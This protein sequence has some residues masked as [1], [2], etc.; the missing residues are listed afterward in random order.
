MPR[1][2]TDATGST[3]VPIDRLEV[4]AYTV[5]TDAPES[6]GKLEWDSTT[7]V[8]VTAGAGGATGLG[9][10]YQ[11]A[12]AAH[13]IDDLLAP[14]LVGRDALRV[15][16]RW[17]EMVRAVRN[18][19]FPGIAAYAI[20]AVDLALW[21][22]KTRLLDLSLV[23]LLDAV[24][25]AV[26][27]Y[28]SG[29]FTSYPVERLI[30]QLAGW[31]AEGFPAVKMKVGRHPG[32]DAARVAAV[33]RAVGDGV[34][35]FVDANGAFQRQAALRQGALF[36]EHRVSWFEEPVSSDDV[37]GLRLLRDRLPAGMEVAAGEYGCHLGE[38][39]RLL[40]AGAVDCL[41]ADITRCG[42][43]TGTRPVG[44]LCQANQIELS[45]HTAPQ[46]SAHVFAAVGPLRHIEWFHDHVRLEG[47]LFDGNLPVADGLVRPDRT[48]PG[49]GLTLKERDV[50]PHRVA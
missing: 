21:D 1:E 2:L 19:R 6:D 36:D 9:Y 18:I 16:A 27:V 29:G 17:T 31:V 48:R 13:L 42:G 30:D 7:I 28:G 20:S 24:H 23:D 22:L 45:A 25:D 41:Q 15:T 33:R 5:P 40:D 14:M 34:E 39:R 49:H 26:P 3:A 37:D 12:S 8:V 50:E 10:T 4:R 43:I 32:T 44:D 11:H 35:L 38:F 47:L 46:L